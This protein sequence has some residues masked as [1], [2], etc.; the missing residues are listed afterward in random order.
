M[1]GK[2]MLASDE[3]CCDDWI[4]VSGDSEAYDCDS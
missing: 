4:D 3:V 2:R 1:D